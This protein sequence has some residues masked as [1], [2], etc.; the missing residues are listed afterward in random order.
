MQANGSSLMGDDV[1]KVNYNF[2]EQLNLK[3]KFNKDA[4]KAGYD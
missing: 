4:Q 1:G 3:C 2:A